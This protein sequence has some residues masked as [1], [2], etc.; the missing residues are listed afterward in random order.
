MFAVMVFDCEL[1][2]PVELTIFQTPFILEYI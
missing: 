2:P 1:L